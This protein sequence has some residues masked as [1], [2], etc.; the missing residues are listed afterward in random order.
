MTWG[1]NVVPRHRPTDVD[2]R[3]RDLVDPGPV[4]LDAEA[5]SG[6]HGDV[7]V[8][9]VDR[10]GDDVAGPE[11]P[12][13]RDVAR[14]REPVERGERGVGGPADARLQHPAAPHRH[15]A[16]AAQVVDAPGRQVPADA[17]G[18]DVDD[19]GGPEVDGVGGDGQRR[20]RLVEAHRRADR[21]G[22]LG[23]AEQVVL[24]QGLLDEQQVEVVEAGE[25]LGVLAGVGG[26]GV[27]LQRDV[28]AR[29]AGGPRSTGSMSQPG[30][31]F[32]L[33]RT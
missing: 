30:S 16:L 23:V 17:A 15:A 14:Q 11:A 10:R 18:L 20:D 4:E 22:Q 9:D 2:R 33:I 26:V 1:R 13:R 12:G 21:P 29:S 19:L 27:D 28:R 25:V 3:R 8:D 7:A 31:I 32:S 24:G 5:G 6:G